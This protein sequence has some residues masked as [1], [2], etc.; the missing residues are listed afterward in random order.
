MATQ[1]VI[2]QLH[3]TEP[4]W[5]AVKTRSKGEKKAVELMLKKGI[6]A[7]TPLQKFQRRYG[8]QK[9]TVELPLL[10]CYTFVHITKS[11]YVPVLETEHVTGFLRVGPNLIAIPED[12]IDLLRRIVLEEG[13]VI[14]VTH[15]AFTEGE[16]VEINRGALFGVRGR[17]VDT[18][19]NQKKI[20]IE[21][22]EI[23]QSLLIMVEAEMVDKV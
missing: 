16:M 4:R 5:F 23:G 15:S 2:N 21:L 1:A 19:N 7:W 13:L 20:Q 8:R 14:E 3:E 17:V 12:Q 9:R 11:A 6:H 10:N 22:Q 18:F